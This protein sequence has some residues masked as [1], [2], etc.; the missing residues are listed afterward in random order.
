ML[1][2]KK[3]MGSIPMEED[4]HAYYCRRGDNSYKTNAE[5]KETGHLI[6]SGI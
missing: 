2:K 1:S 4:E 6:S 5:N 3:K